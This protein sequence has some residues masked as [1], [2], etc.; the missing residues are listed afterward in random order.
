MANAVKNLS[1]YGYTIVSVA[2]GLL[3]VD[4]TIEFDA[5]LVTRV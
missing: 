3:D 1:Q 5:I 4:M 2:V